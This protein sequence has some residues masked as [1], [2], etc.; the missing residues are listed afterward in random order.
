MFKFQ[1]LLSI[2]TILRDKLFSSINILGLTL[3]ITS[4]L[5]L[6]I[7]V[8]DE[9]KVDR[10]HA[11]LNDLYR[12]TTHINSDVGLN[13]LGTSSPAVA[14]GIKNDIPEI[15]KVARIVSPP[16]VSQNLIRFGDKTLY[17]EHGLL[18]DST[19][20]D[21]LTYDFKEGNPES[22][23]RLANTV[24]LNEVLAEKLFGNES[25]LGKSIQIS[26]EG[27][28]FNYEVTGVFRN[29]TTSFFKA[30]FFIS[31]TSDSWW[32]KYLR[33]PYAV[34][35]WTGS[36]FVISL[37]RLQPDHKLA[38][39]ERKINESLILHA[40]KSMEAHGLKKELRL[41]PI[42]DI[43]L[44]SAINQ[45]PR[46]TALYSVICIAVFIL[47]LACINF[48][49]LTTAK[50][51]RRAIEVGIKK[52]IGADRKVL[53]MQYIGEATLIV[54]V[55]VLI[56]IG[57]AQLGLPLLNQITGKF[58]SLKSISGTQLFFFC[59]TIVLVTGLIAGSYPAF[60]LSSFHPAKILKGKSNLSSSS[61]LLRKSLVVF[62]FSICIVLTAGA[63][64]VVKQ[65]QYTQEK[66]LGFN[67]SSQLVIPLR[68][69]EARKQYETLKLQI[70]TLEGVKQ[71]SAT[72]YLPGSYVYRDQLVYGPGS[73]TDKA[74]MVYKNMV[75]HNY[76]DLLQIPI[77]AGRNFSD[78]RKAESANRLIVNR[79]ALE[80]LNIDISNAVGSPLYVDYRGEVTTYEIIGVMENYHQ[81][82]L[83][84]PINPLAFWVPQGSTAYSYIIVNYETANTK[85]LINQLKKEWQS[86]INETPF[87]FTFLE[88]SI[89]QHYEKDRKLSAVVTAFMAVA[90][91]ISCLGLYGLS[92][93]MAERRVKEIGIRKVLGA[94]TNQIVAMMS[95]EFLVLVLI[96]NLLAIPLALYLMNNWLESFAF[97]ITIRPEIFIFTT[98]ATF[99]IALATILFESYT[100][101]NQ[102][103]VNAL[104]NE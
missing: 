4:C 102:N 49:N 41:E 98:L 72:S 19:L 90:I 104:R 1:L 100:A 24:V 3:G 68:T 89:Q 40:G 95:K 42:K 77:I 70:G 51:S 65:L 67:A 44:R 35:E 54:L 52:V 36:N 23:L 82:T 93:Y 45:V 62:Q 71:V 38:D 57:L 16:G 28:F 10:H 5:L 27:E 79:A 22:S 84:K 7:Y 26:Q 11:H 87:E 37:L 76:I 58:L 92:S 2:R 14:W 88:E 94:R 6:G 66:N 15:E 59:T 8:F 39:V 18:A 17:E 86:A 64:I 21:I 61:N 73:S 99:L 81:E 50:V 69:A 30:G 53:I 103:P 80:E 63:L 75:D 43:Y 74:K 55:A 56:S 29:S 60:Y 48:I 34:D 97:H 12:I 101:A 25:A 9:L 85:N 91:L 46:I 78:N 31:M 20:F 32:A 96:A 33:G 83:H 13:D 47:L